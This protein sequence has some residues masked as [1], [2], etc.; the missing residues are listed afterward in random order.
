MWS[1]ACWLLLL[2]VG[3]GCQQLRGTPVLTPA[4]TDHYRNLASTVEQAEPQKSVTR[5]LPSSAAPLS[6]TNHQPTEEWPLKLDE[7]IVLSLS[8]STVLRDLGGAILRSPTTVGTIHGPQIVETDPRFGIENALSAFDAHWATQVFYERNDRALNNTFFG[9]G[10]RLLQQDLSTWQSSLTKLAATGTQFTVRH[11]TDYDANNAPG[12]Q[13]PSAWNTNF[14]TEFRHPLLQGAGVQY[15][16]IAGPTGQPGLFNGVVLARI[17]TDMSQAD[18][19]IG[20]RNLVADVENAY[21]DLYFA[22]RDLNAKVLARNSA[23]ETWRRVHALYASQKRGGEA[24]KEAQ[25][26][27]QYFRFQEEV[28]NALS[29]PLVE[30]THTHNGTAGGTF[31]GTPGVHLAERRLRLVIGVP[32][33][34]GRLIKPADEPHAAQVVFDWDQV[35]RDTLSRRPELRRQRWLI[36]RREMELIASKNLLLPRFDGVGRYRWRGFGDDLLHTQNLSGNRFDNAYDNLL[37]GDFQEWQVGVDFNA[38]LGFRKAHNAVRNGQ[39]QLARERSLLAEQEREVLAGVS[40]ALADFQRA[41]QVVQTSYNRMLAARDQLQTVQAAYDA[42]KSPLESVLEA[43]RRMIEA[44]VRHHR[45]RVELIISLRNVHFEKG[46]SLDFNDVFLNGNTSDGRLSFEMAAQ[47][48]AIDYR[49][50]RTVTAP[51]NPAGPS[52]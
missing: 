4:D 23:L 7:A 5:T 17:N 9:G 40:N 13:F 21:W 37:S 49:M 51:L 34:D 1:V 16:R 19:E 45:A 31:R 24:D 6:I 41:Q 3:G 12:N 10:T 39:L 25:A 46:T 52:P 33:N 8:N 48:P 20:V 27:E 42:E 11:N 50:Q 43:Q 32:I 2:T 15:N 47:A 44:E 18:F 30:G 26:R 36:K 38:P 22:Y 29:G 14:E 28:E 35:V